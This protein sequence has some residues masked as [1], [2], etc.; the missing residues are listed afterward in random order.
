[1]H[2]LLIKI[3]I[4]QTDKQL[5]ILKVGYI[6]YKLIMLLLL[7]SVFASCQNQ[8]SKA[9]RGIANIP[10]AGGAIFLRSFLR[11][12]ES[13]AT[14]LGSAEIDKLMMSYM[15]KSSYDDA[16]GAVVPNWKRA[17]LQ[18]ESDLN[19]IKSFYDDVHNPNPNL[20]RIS[21]FVE[22]EAHLIFQS[23]VSR[24]LINEAYLAVKKNQ[25][26]LVNH[27]IPNTGASSDYVRFN[28]LKPTS[29]KTSY[30]TKMGRST[31]LYVFRAPTSAKSELARTGKFYTQLSRTKKD[32]R[33]VVSGRRIVE[34]HAEASHVAGYRTIG[35][36]CENFTNP[37]YLANKADVD[38]EFA[39][40]VKKKNLKSKIELAQAGEDALARE[41][42]LTKTEANK[43]FCVLAASNC[44]F[45]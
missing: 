29:N 41:L 12:I 37:K 25:K 43:V 30:T 26:I 23:R 38:D 15:R 14:R 34:A 18:S 24:E 42:R 3:P 7:I 36:G 44:G 8:P 27:F 40:I 13:K 9:D 4:L 22:K 19:G 10:S 39:R 16:Y 17:G 11:E 31:D 45:F 1:M 33:I 20:K 2:N 6:M 21:R 28:R 5:E 35:K 32:P